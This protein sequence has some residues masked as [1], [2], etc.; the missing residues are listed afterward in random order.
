[1]SDTKKVIKA[2]VAVPATVGLVVAAG[3][4][5]M[6][7]GAISG[8]HPSG[9]THAAAHKMLETTIHGLWKWVER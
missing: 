9:G 7:V 4:V 2:I 1:M 6:G 5:L 8:G 3:A